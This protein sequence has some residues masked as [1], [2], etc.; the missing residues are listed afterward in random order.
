MVNNSNENTKY[1][2][3]RIIPKSNRNFVERCTIDNRSTA[4]HDRSLTSIHDRSL[5][6]IHDRSPTCLGTE[7]LFSAGFTYGLDR[8]KP[9]A[10]TFRGPPAKVYFLFDVVIGLSHLCCHNVLYFLNNPSV[11][12]LTQLDS[13][14]EYCRIWNTLHQLRLYSNLQSWRRGIGRGLTRIIA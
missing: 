11:I 5:T 8:P 1:L 13:I 14:S 2:P 6:S 10:S 12:F 4:M 9:R 7:T 3:V